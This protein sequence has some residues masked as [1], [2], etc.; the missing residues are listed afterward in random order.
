MSKWS[1][2]YAKLIQAFE[3]SSKPK[4]KLTGTQWANSNFYLSAESSSQPGKVTLYPYQ[5]EIVDCM[6]DNTT[7]FVT[8]KK[9]ARI[10]YNKMLNMAV[11]YF[12]HQD[13]CS[14]LFVNPTEDEAYGVGESEIEP[15]IRDNKVISALVH[16]KNTVGKT[17][18][19]KTTKKTYPGGILELV[20]AVSPRSFRRRT[21]RVAIFD[22]VNGYD[23]EVGTEGDAIKLGTKRTNDFYNRKVIIGST[24]TVKKGSK[25]TREIKKSDGRR[26][27]LPCPHC[28]N[29]HPLVFEDLVWELDADN[30]VIDSSVG[31][32]CKSCERVIT[33][34]HHYSMD[35]KGEW[36]A[37][38]QYRGHAGFDDIWAAYS[39]SANSSWVQIAKDYIE[40]ERDPSLMQPFVNT[41]LGRDYD[42]E[43][44]KVDVK[45][46]LDKKETYDYEVPDGAVVL[47]CGIDTQD[48]RL[49]WEVKAFG[50]NKE[51]WSIAKGVFYGD[52]ADL[53]VFHDLDILLDREFEHRN[54]PMRIHTACIDRGGHKTEYVDEYCRTRAHRGIYPIIGSRTIDAPIIHYR[55]PAKDQNG[56][57]KYMTP[58]YLIGVNAI[59][60]VVVPGILATHGGGPSYCHYPD[61]DTYDEA[62]FDQLIAEHRDASGRWVKAR[63]GIRN[64]GVDLHVYN[65]AAYRIIQSKGYDIDRLAKGGKL[66]YNI[67]RIKKKKKRKPGVVSQVDVWDTSAEDHLY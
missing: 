44:E 58:F 41:V 31:F 55:K 27:Y 59:K 24:P 46:L 67:G 63:S 2:Q 10:G 54:G 7:N 42:T 18:I 39:Y 35:L 14:I 62:Y 9:G 32:K 66:L 5:E 47:T 3:D 20:G 56:R 43:E 52:P 26:R 53:E 16:N 13:P 11:G 23:R 19:D 34:D 57:T 60:N 45:V 36:R 51:S 30:E 28:G 65:Y 4:P 8:V 33:Q 61:Q 25:I 38:R 29:M 50:E 12:I 64:E 48:N 15:M 21:V 37:E 49:E 17:K 6:T 1:G 22:E 40:A